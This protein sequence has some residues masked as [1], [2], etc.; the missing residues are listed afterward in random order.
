MA[1]KNNFEN[2]ALC[3]TGAIWARYCF[4]IV[5]KNYYLASV[6]IFLCLVGL[7][8]LLRIANFEV[9]FINIS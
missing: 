4:V 5:P 7:V 1:N 8:Q 3:A 6:N 9:F 2:A